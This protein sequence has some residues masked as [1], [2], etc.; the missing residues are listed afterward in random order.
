VAVRDRRL[1]GTAARGDLAEQAQRAGLPAPLAVLARQAQRAR[2]EFGG[3]IEAV[4]GQGNL[5]QRHDGP[6][7]RRPHPRGL[8]RR[9]D[10]LEDRH[11][12]GETM[13]PGVA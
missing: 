9:Q 12:V 11:A 4:V 7:L 13:R 6:G 10:L 8:R 3:E 2:A 1:R 5:A